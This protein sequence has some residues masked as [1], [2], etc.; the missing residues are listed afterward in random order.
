MITNLTFK[1]LKNDNDF[2]SGLHNEEFILVIGAGFSYGVQNNSSSDCKTIPLG[3]KFLE[4]TNKKFGSETGEYP[5]AASLWKDE[6]L[7]DI[8][9][10]N[11]FK[12]LFLAN[13]NKFNY[14]NFERIF[15]PNWFK[16]YTL[17]FDNVLDLAMRNIPDNYLFFSYPNDPINSQKSISHL[18]G[19]ITNEFKFDDIVFSP[20]DYIES[21]KKKHTLYTSFHGDV[22]TFKKHLIII[23]T[24]FTEQAV[25]SNFFDGLEEENIK[26]YHF[27]LSNNNTKL[28]PQFKQQDYKFIQ[29]TKGVIE[30]FDFFEENRHIIQKID[31]EGAKVID[32]AFIEDLEIKTFSKND[33]YI[34]KLSNDCQW[35]GCNKEWGIKRSF[36]NELKQTVISSFDE[37]RVSNVSA[38]VYGI[39]G[40]GKSTQ[41]RI[42]ALELYNEKFKT[43]W[44]ENFNTFNE[45]SINIIENS[46]YLHFLIII[47]DWYRLSSMY[48]DSI[49]E[50]FNKLSSFSHVRL[51]IGDRTLKSIYSNKLYNGEETK[52]EILA[53]ENKDII[54]KIASKIPEWKNICI[55]LYQNMGLQNTSLFSV[56]F[57]ITNIFDKALSSEKIRLLD[58]KGHFIEIVQSDIKKISKIYPGLAKSIVYAANIYEL[59][60][61]KITKE[62]LLAIATHFNPSANFNLLNINSTESGIDRLISNYISETN[63]DSKSD[64]FNQI[65]F[66]QFNHDILAEDGLSKSILD[67]W[68]SFESQMQLKILDIL[69]NLKDDYTTSSYLYHLLKDSN[70]FFKDNV[71][72][73]LNYVRKLYNSNKKNLFFL[74]S[75]LQENSF[76]NFDIK[77]DFAIQILKRFEKEKIAKGKK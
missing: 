73:G 31:L 17:N 38:V 72:L 32:K 42:L 66:V 33:F 67:D 3:K 13:E 12:A 54:Q 20:N 22:K 75:V 11:E 2:L 14:E 36:Y 8:E 34:S 6:S 35:Y 58:I 70:S 76:F 30:I 45:N 16:I 18:H 46:P 65:N 43:I 44:I 1:D 71:N 7:S 23:G 62:A 68:L 53:S 56:L 24:Q 74:Q 26:I 47:E 59:Y 48:K 41:L 50:V 49:K 64:W 19:K 61:I 37:E 9:I 51:V 27:E 5:I 60:K 4:F 55:D 39:G 10:V 52:Y 25:L 40:S 29:L 63:V 77:K 69:T 15:I 21:A 28:L 57:I